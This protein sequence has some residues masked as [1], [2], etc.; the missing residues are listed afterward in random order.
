MT[1]FERSNTYT[2]S[3]QLAGKLLAAVVLATLAFALLLLLAGQAL[4][5]PM[6]RNEILIKDKDIRLGDVFEGLTKH[7]DFILA[8]APMPGEKLVWN[9]P[10]L[11][12]IATAFNLP[13][14]P[15]SG[16]TVS[17]KRAA[18]L[19][20]SGTVKAVL[21]DHLATLND[22]DSFNIT[23]HGDV[24]E[25]IVPSL[26]MPTLEVADFNMPQNGGPFSAIVRVTAPTGKKQDVTLR[27]MA[28]RMVHLPVLKHTLRSGTVI[29]AGDVEWITVS[30]TAVKRDMAQNAE[31][32]IGKTP[33]RMQVAG[34][35]ISLNDLDTP[36]LVTR[37]EVVMMVYNHNGM[38]LTA[39][40][41]AMEDGS[42]GQTIRVSNLGS[43]RQ[44]EARVTARKQVTVTH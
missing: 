18:T 23:L 31:D 40:G 24:P 12:R 9:E 3:A 36:L 43:N 2:L 8:P 35:A 13:W 39:K 11:K 44:I 19:I 34:T 28:E 32:I 14:R 21:R 5:G 22:R 7:A 37:G 41:R 27:G 6:P 29:D 30:A 20:D 17:I 1:T 42:A 15:Q 26:E 25:I 38:Y 33:R 16:Q 10:T 4:A